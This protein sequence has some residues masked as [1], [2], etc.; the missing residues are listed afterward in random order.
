MDRKA[1]SKWYYENYRKKG[2]LK[3]RDKKKKQEE[4]RIGSALPEKNKNSK[5]K[6][7]KSSKITLTTG[8]LNEKGKKAAS[9][10]K[11]FLR[12]ERDA[13][14]N[15]TK[16]KAKV[17][18]AELR[19]SL[20]GLSK[21]QRA[22][23]KDEV[24]AKI[25]SIQES[26]K[27]EK[28]KVDN[29]YKRK[30]SYALRKLKT[31][32]KYQKDGSIAGLSEKASAKA[33]E[34]KANLQKEKSEYIRQEAESVREEISSL[35][36]ELA[37]EKQSLTEQ[38]ESEKKNRETELKNNFDSQIAELQGKIDNLP[39]ETP[40]EQR[41]QIEKETKEAIAQLKAQYKT[42]SANLKSEMAERKKSEMADLIDDFDLAGRVSELRNHLADIRLT[43]KEKYDNRYKKE[44]KALKAKSSSWR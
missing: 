14:I 37:E 5:T 15:G 8:G 40:E 27:A 16:E 43:A 22:A 6:S 21:S 11:E 44:L 20:K 19:N 17:Q 12:K 7:S 38:L 1:Y 36:E 9:K 25:K 34:I 2:K 4:P 42:D 41:K 39:T 13:K 31:D 23:R 26:V 24:Y 29:E 10:I 35:R 18:I 3:G 33:K 32:S 28:E 30:Y